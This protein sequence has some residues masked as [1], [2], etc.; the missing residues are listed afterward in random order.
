MIVRNAAAI[1]LIL[2]LAAAIGVFYIDRISLLYW[3]NLKTAEITKL[4]L[5]V[6]SLESQEQTVPNRP[7]S[8][9]V[10]RAVTQE[11]LVGTFTVTYYCDCVSCCGNTN[12]VTSSGSKVMEGVTVA[13]DSKVFPIGSYLYIEGVGMRV[14]TDRG[15]AIKGKRLDVY[16][17]SHQKALEL[18]KHKAKVYLLEG[19]K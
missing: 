10:D 7:P 13:A 16:V 2:C 17:K 1:A 14:V 18:G 4:K 5:E 3:S 6:Y 15:G 9:E 11:L 12:G 19:I 8:G